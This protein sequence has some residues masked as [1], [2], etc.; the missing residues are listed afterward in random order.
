MHSLISSFSVIMS[1]LKI[2]LFQLLVELELIDKVHAMV[3]MGDFLDKFGTSIMHLVVLSQPT[4]NT[5]GKGNLMFKYVVQCACS[6]S[7]Y[8]W[9]VSIS[10]WD[11]CL[12]ECE[13]FT[14]R[15]YPSLT[16][17]ISPLVYYYRFSP[18][19]VRPVRDS[20]AGTT[21]EGQSCRYDQ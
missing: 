1:D 5:T 10:A 13:C 3:K 4:Q 9:V 16:E 2:L 21:S 18:V 19:R 20:R 6:V 14:T 8:Q 11:E 17:G 7:V 15:I 12:W